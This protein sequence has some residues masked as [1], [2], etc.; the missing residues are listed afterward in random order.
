MLG[1]LFCMT[2]IS[3][4][5]VSQWT[6]ASGGND[7]YYQL[8]IVPTGITWLD[9]STA[10]QNAGGYLA[11][12]T[13]T[14][15]NTFVYNL[16]AQ[17]SNAWFID[18]PANGLG[19]W[20]GGYQSPSSS[21]PTGGWNWVSGETWSYTNWASGEPNNNA[22]IE[23]K[24]QLFGSQTLMAATWNDLPSSGNADGPAHA[25]VIEFN[26]TPVPEPS[27]YAAILGCAALLGSIVLRRK[28]TALHSSSRPA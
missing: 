6:A 27:T 21:E 4:G 15:E 28:K 20:L 2:G 17:D 24:L 3:Q 1:L 23:D 16:A 7:H 11:T 25:Y 26:T 5:Q 18:T 10:A 13:S 19:P 8:V 14:P 9:A 12:L 22:G